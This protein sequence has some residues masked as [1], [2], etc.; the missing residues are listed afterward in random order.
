MIN[1][2]K[3]RDLPMSNVYSE[4]QIKQLTFLTRILEFKEIKYELISELHRYK[5]KHIFNSGIW[6][7][8]L[9]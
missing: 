9:L 6:N 3:L 4:Q 2:G 1:T 5:S 8:V 7:K